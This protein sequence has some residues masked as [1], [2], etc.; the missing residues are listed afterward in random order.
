MP[1]TDADSI[2]SEAA[3]KIA[4]MSVPKLKTLLAKH[5]SYP[6][7]FRM[8]VIRH[9]LQVKLKRQ[10]ASIGPSGPTDAS[11]MKAVGLSSGRDGG[12]LF[13]TSPLGVLCFGRQLPS[14]VDAFASLSTRE[15]HAAWADLDKR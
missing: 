4:A 15:P 14:N 1:N 7:K 5:G 8:T 3:N 9:L 10:S 2:S 12:C 13:R 6:D 11:C